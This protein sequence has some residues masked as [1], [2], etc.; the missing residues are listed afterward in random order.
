MSNQKDKRW[1]DSFGLISKGND[2][3][4]KDPKIHE[5]F[6]K[7]LKRHYATLIDRVNNDTLEDSFSNLTLNDQTLSLNEQQ[8]CLYLFRQLREGITASQ[9]IDNFTC[10]LYETSVRVG[11]YMN[12]VESYVPALCYLLEVIYPKLLKPFAQNQMVT[13]YLLYLC[14]LRNFQGLYEMKNK[15]EL[16]AQDIPFEFSKILIQNNYIAWWKLRQRVPWLY[17]RLIDLSREQIQER[18]V[19][20]IKASYYKI[21]KKW[22][23]TYIGLALFSKTGWIIEDSWIKIRE[24]GLPK[25]T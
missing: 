10:G 9:R 7:R 11:I 18:C 22:M 20:V 25:I 1:L 14:S 15:W 24:P 3:R 17:Q 12:H 19:S 4:L 13:C 16:D 21:T 5:I 8:H 23:E 2:N 6:Y